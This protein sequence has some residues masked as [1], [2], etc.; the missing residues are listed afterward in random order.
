[1]SQDLSEYQAYDND[2]VSTLVF[3]DW[4]ECVSDAVVLYPLLLSI[5]E[6]LEFDITI[7]ASAFQGE[8]GEDG[9]VKERQPKTLSRWIERDKK[10]GFRLISLYELKKPHGSNFNY[11]RNAV[12]TNIGEKTNFFAIYFEN[13]A[14]KFNLEYFVSVVKRLEKYIR[15]KY[16]MAFQM[17]QRMKPAHY[18]QGVGTGNLG[19]DEEQRRG[20]WCNDWFFDRAFLS[21]KIRDVY[22]YNFLSTYHINKNIDYNGKQIPFSQ[23]VGLE[24]VGEVNPISETLWCWKVPPNIVSRARNLLL[25]K[26]FLV[27]TV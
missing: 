13:R 20:D 11:G 8:G 15:P 7:T 3:Y 22:P 6:E 14:E 10:S 27:V 18:V 12:Q 26:G 24:M 16:G 5:S 19:N 25:K 17:P 2:V 21:Q 1:M 23:W 9:L 4:D